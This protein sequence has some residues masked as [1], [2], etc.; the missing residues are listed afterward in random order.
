MVKNK[1]ELELLSTEKHM[2]PP[3]RG[4]KDQN[5]SKAF[6]NQKK[7][8]PN[9]NKTEKWLLCLT[10]RLIVLYDTSSYCALNMYEVSCE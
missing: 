6:A 10:P 1:R 2:S 9:I 3:F 5:V 4:Q 7:I 8:T